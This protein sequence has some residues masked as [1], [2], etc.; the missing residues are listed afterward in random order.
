MTKTAGNQVG[1][2]LKILQTLSYIE[3]RAQD[4]QA[5]QS[6]AQRHISCFQGQKRDI[7]LTFSDLFLTVPI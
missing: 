6:D 1:T 5:N 4:A 7:I 2:L 3:L